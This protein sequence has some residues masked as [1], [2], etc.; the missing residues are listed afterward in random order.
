MVGEGFIGVGVFFFYLPLS[1]FFFYLKETGHGKTLQ[2]TLSD[3]N[4]K[5]RESSK[6]SV[7]L[8]AT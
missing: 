4:E 6:T 8:E 7:A 3:A 1:I 5:L 2:I